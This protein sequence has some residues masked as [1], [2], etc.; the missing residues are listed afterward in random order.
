MTKISLQELQKL[1][2]I[3]YISLQIDE[4]E[5]LRDQLDQVLSYA[6]RVSDMG[7]DIPEITTKN[8]N[9]WREDAAN[10]CNNAALLTAAPHIIGTYFVVPIIL[11]DNN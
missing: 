2:T 10:V 4:L 8:I 3:S 1:G 9:V 11:D 7:A 6:S 5:P